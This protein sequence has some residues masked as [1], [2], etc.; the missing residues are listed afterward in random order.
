MKK[1]FKII[2]KVIIYLLIFTTLITGFVIVSRNNN[3]AK[4]N[5]E[6]LAYKMQPGK[7]E[8]YKLSP[9]NI[10][11]I[12]KRINEGNIHGMHHIPNEIL[13]NGVVISFGGS[14]G[15]MIDPLANYLS[16]DGYEVVA[17]TYF[18]QKGQPENVERIPVEIYKEIIYFIKKYCQNSDTITIVGISRGAELGLLMSTY[19][20]SIDNLVLIAPSGYVNGSTFLNKSS[21]W[22]YGGKDIDYLNGKINAISRLNVAINRILNK[23]YEQLILMN[24]KVKNSTNLEEARIK[25]EN[26]NVKILIFYGGDDRFI[27][28]KSASKTIEKYAQN[29]IIIKGY[30]NAGHAFSGGFIV[31][32]ILNGGDPVSNIEADLDSKRVL[33]ETLELWHK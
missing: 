3:Q 14:E 18:G 32:G 2:A 17:I 22:R 6:L 5:E 28:A 29:D 23:P 26:S 21:A 13:H 30:E 9:R 12:K 33:L 1:V 16:S 24:S 25:V 10:G 7:D 8:M 19:Y 31:E 11:V 4:I 15:G 20:D 27:D